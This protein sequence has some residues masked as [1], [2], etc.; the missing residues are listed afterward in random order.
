MAN[1]TSCAFPL[2][3]DGC[4]ISRVATRDEPSVPLSYGNDLPGNVYPSK[5]L[6][7]ILYRTS[8]FVPR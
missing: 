3:S 8:H 1:V 6:T 2:G 5:D 4:R 7:V